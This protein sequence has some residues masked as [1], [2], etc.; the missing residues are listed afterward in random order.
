MT[1]DVFPDPKT[2]FGGRVRQRLRDEQ[3]IW[4]TTVGD[5]GTPEPNPVWFIDEGDTILV[6]N[7]LGAHRL[8]HMRR[9]PQVSLHFNSDGDGNDIVVLTGRAAIIA[10]HPLPHETLS[11]MDKY[12]SAAVGVSGTAEAFSSA[13]PT[14]VRISVDRVRGG[15]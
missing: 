1:N 3:V 11:Y 4:L 2:P 15:V 8:D 5:N 13:Y 10:D 7:Q 9:D 6:F 12:R 14:A